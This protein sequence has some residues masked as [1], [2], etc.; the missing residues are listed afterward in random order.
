MLRAQHPDPRAGG[1]RRAGT[2]QG[3]GGDGL[4]ALRSGSNALVID[5]TTPTINGLPERQRA[6]G[7]TGAGAYFHG[8]TTVIV[9]AEHPLVGV[10]REQSVS[11]EIYDKS[12]QFRCDGIT[13]L[14]RDVYHRAKELDPS[15][16]VSAAVFVNPASARV[17]VGQDWPA[18]VREAIIEIIAPMNYSADTEQTSERLRDCLAAMS[19]PERIFNGISAY[20]RGEDG[21]TRSRPT[22]LV[23]AQLARTRELGREGVVIF[24][25]GWTSDELH[26]ALGDGPFSE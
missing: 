21:K 16:K 19:E 4:S 23:L 2:P 24:D 18:W 25:S 22:A 9:P 12:V 7:L 10:A 5:G 14:V 13:A 6:Y 8:E 26:L 11:A 1:R 15:L 20:I 17:S 3:A